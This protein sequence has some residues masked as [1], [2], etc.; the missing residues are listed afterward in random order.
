MPPRIAL[1]AG[2]KKLENNLPDYPHWKQKESKHNLRKKELELQEQGKCYTQS[3]SME[4][5]EELATSKN[6][7]EAITRVRPE[8]SKQGPKRS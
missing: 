5:L 7:E 4:I 1:S 3:I 6:S 8:Q 2:K